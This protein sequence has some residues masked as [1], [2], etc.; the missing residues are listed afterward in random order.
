MFKVVSQGQQKEEK[1]PQVRHY[2]NEM[3]L[4]IYL[5]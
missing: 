5:S 4:Q 2:C 3:T 1:D